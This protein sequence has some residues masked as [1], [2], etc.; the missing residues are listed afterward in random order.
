MFNDNI[1]YYNFKMFSRKKIM[2][3]FDKRFNRKV[4]KKLRMMT[5]LDKVQFFV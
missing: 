5:K 2:N 3:Y 1:K 4:I